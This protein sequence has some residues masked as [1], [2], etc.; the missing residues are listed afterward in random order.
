MK[1][2]INEF[3][4]DKNSF[5][6]CFSICSTIWFLAVCILFGV[7]IWRSFEQVTP[8]VTQYQDGEYNKQGVANGTISIN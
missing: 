7:Y 4:Q 6:L 3:R 5:V 2:A 8:S 1:Q